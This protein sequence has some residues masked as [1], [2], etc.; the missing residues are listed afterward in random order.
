MDKLALLRKPRSSKRKVNVSRG[1]AHPLRYNEVPPLY[2][3]M[4]MTGV[5]DIV[6]VIVVYYFMP[7]SFH[8]LTTYL[9]L[10]CLQRANLYI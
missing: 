6:D 4:S 7:T 5:G 1:Q 8:N 3:S 2:Y 10:I 9:L